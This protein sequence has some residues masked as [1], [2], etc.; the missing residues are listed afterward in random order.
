MEQG[1]N[2]VVALGIGAVLGFPFFIGQRH[3]E[4]FERIHN[5]YFIA[6]LVLLIFFIT[7]LVSYNK[8]V[9]DQALKAEV[10][11]ALRIKDLFIGGYNMSS[12]NSVFVIAASI[13]Q[14][15][16]MMFDSYFIKPALRKIRADK[17]KTP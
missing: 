12:V 7:V 17:Q 6:S 1:M 14:M 2:V 13:Y 15:A 11:Q 5:L 8:G 3:P 9:S 4:E 10:S 16:L